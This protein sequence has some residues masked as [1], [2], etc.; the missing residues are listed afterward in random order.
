M[1][2]RRTKIKKVETEAV[3]SSNLK[4]QGVKETRVGDSYISLA[5]GIIVVIAI[6]A[7]IAAFVR[8]NRYRVSTPPPTEQIDIS[9][10]SVQRTYVLQEGEGLWD[11]AVKFYG[12]GFKWTEL[13]KANKLDNPDFIAPGTV[14]IIPALQ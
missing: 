4:N 2:R 12:D 1:A 14:L 5:L 13:V 10:E 6:A 11:V 3:A 9:E 7:V 8:G